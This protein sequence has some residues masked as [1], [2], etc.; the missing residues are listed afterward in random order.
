M[1][2]G[3]NV[4]SHISIIPKTSLTPSTCVTVHDDDDGFE[5]SALLLPSLI[6]ALSKHL[7]TQFCIL[8]YLVHEH[9]ITKQMYNCGW[10]D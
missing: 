2:L 7:S 10:F 1:V 6:A 3:I 8:L 9:L 4:T 5:V